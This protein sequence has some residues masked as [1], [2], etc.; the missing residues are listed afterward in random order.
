MVP[1]LII[2]GLYIERQVP[3]SINYDGEVF[4]EAFRADLIVES[5]VI[6][7]LKSTEQ[8][9]KVYHKQL[10]TYLRL[11]NRNLGF[12]LNFRAPLM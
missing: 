11:S 12:L 3:I 8:V 9:N 4:N 5:K 2:Q 1:F 6:L 10:L 7:E